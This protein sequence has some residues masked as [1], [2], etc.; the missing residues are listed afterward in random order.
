MKRVAGPVTFSLV[1]VASSLAQAEPAV[2]P[3]AIAR[4]DKLLE[5]HAE[6]SKKVQVLVATYVQRRTTELSK[7]P[8][9]SRGEF[10]FVRDPACVVFRATTPR[11]SIVRLRG[12]TY[13]VYRPQKKQLERFHLEGPELAEALFAAIGGDIAV[14]RRNF[15]I[16]DCVADPVAG[17][18]SIR[19]APRTVLVRERLRQLII[20]VRSS[21][22]VLCAV[23][24]R[25]GAGDLVE[26]ELQEPRPN[27]PDPP[28][29]EF[30]VGK[31]TTIVEHAPPK[32]KD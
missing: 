23:A 21:D 3:A 9:V 19:L 11:V 2:D 31:D 6:Q 4:A 10:L 27:P 12:T 30:D 5:A 22:G 18:A 32:K 25:D 13:E 24:Y 14:L 8:L 7:E 20:T 16:Q 29:A 17:R 28:S 1:V 26:I 15:A